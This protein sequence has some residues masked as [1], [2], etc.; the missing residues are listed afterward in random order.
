MYSCPFTF[1]Y[2]F[3]NSLGW[4]CYH[5]NGYMVVYHEF[6]YFSATCVVGLQ[7][8]YLCR[9]LAMKG[10][11]LLQLVTPQHLCIWLRSF[12]IIPLEEL[13]QALWWQVKKK[14]LWKLQMIKTWIPHGHCH[15]V[16]LAI[17]FN[18]IR[19]PTLRTF[20]GRSLE[21]K[22]TLDF[23]ALP[24]QDQIFLVTTVST[25]KIKKISIVWTW[26]SLCN[27]KILLKPRRKK[28]AP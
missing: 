6:P 26:A 5:C 13:S 16:L 18:H 19:S 28:L 21:M 10:V 9:G 7:M 12:F 20:H 27:F 24:S 4:F 3:Y 15:S 1:F 8:S 11:F 23:I 2:F 17:H 14:N 25:V 22:M